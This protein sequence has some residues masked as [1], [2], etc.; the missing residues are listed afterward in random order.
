MFNEKTGHMGNI[1]ILSQ[2]GVSY[3]GSEDGG[4]VAQSHKNVI[5]GGG[6]VL[7]PEQEVLEV[8]HQHR[9]GKST[10]SA[11]QHSHT[12]QMKYSYSP[13]LACHSRR[14]ARRTH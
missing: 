7:L 2:P 9:Y 14:S 12:L 11:Q 10:E 8:Q 5:D 1:L 4:E 13:N 3:N 6:E